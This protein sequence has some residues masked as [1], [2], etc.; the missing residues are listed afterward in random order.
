MI[1]CNDAKQEIYYPSLKS[2]KLVKQRFYDD[3]SDDRE[4]LL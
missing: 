3:N 1:V 4:L 2:S